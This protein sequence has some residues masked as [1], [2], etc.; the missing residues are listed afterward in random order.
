ML[1]NMKKREETKWTVFAMYLMRVENSEKDN[2]KLRVCDTHTSSVTVMQW[3]GVN[4][5]RFLT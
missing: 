3:S 4:G 1:T 2:E 5:G